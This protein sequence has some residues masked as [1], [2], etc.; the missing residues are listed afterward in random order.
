VGMAKKSRSILRKN[1]GRCLADIRS[2]VA[3][4]RNAAGMH[5]THSMC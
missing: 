2:P 4:C 3:T 1:Q 5:P